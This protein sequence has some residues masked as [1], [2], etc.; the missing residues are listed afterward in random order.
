MTGDAERKMEFLFR[1]R[2]RGVTNA[3]VLE[4]M[5]RV[6]RG[7][8]VT[9]HFADRAYEDTPLPIPCGNVLVNGPPNQR[10]SQRLP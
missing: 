10:R 2:S 8:F 3:R 9:G 4:A 5:E 1:V 7:A 6:D